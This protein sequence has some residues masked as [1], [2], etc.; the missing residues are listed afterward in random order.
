MTLQRN[1][2]Y[3]GTDMPGPG[4]RLGHDVTMRQRR[5]SPPGDAWRCDCSRE[6]QCSGA[7]QRSAC[8][9]S[10]LLFIFFIA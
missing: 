8:D 6:P 5:V 1:C 2:G 7:R 10:L 9:H 4:R 3:A